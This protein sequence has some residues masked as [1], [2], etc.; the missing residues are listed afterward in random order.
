MTNR[1]QNVVDFV[2]RNPG[3]CIMDVV[4]HEWRGRGHAASY[5]RVHR[6]IRA[7][8]LRMERVG[9]RGGRTALFV[10]GAM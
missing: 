4:N 9:A 8:V 2:A 1:Q 7:G 10:R 6:L 3:C 5:A